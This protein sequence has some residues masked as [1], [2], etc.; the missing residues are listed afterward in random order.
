[1]HKGCIA[2]H[3]K[4][5]WEVLLT[6]TNHENLLE[7]LAVLVGI[8]GDSQVSSVRWIRIQGEPYL[9][10]LGSWFSEDC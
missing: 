7:H 1:M 10:R 3:T 9:A 4:L 8:Q 5:V 2:W 6:V